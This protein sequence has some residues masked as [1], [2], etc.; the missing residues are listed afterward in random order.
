MRLM[1]R[2]HVLRPLLSDRHRG[3]GFLAYAA[4]G[5]KGLCMGTCVPHCNAAAV[6]NA[7]GSCLALMAIVVQA[8]LQQAEV[9][10]ALLACQA[11]G[12]LL[13]S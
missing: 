8:V 10:A 7:G 6:Q 9:A 1:Q 4:W 5:L 3:N 12:E 2:V 13:S 11:S